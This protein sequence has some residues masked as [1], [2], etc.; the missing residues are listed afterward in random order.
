DAE[1]V[2]ELNILKNVFFNVSVQTSVGLIILLLE[3]CDLLHPCPHISDIVLLEL[4]L[5]LLLVHLLAVSYLDFKLLLYTPQ[6]FSVSLSEGSF[7][8]VKQVLLVIQGLLLGKHLTVL[9]GMVVSTE[10]FI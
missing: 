6:E 1:L 9:V 4:A 3:A 10:K 2:S 8:L 7:F 5:Q